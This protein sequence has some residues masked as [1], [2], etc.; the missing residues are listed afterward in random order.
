MCKKQYG[1]QFFLHFRKILKAPYILL[2]MTLWADNRCIDLEIPGRINCEEF[3]K[4]ELMLLQHT[5]FLIYALNFAVFHNACFHYFI[6]AKSKSNYVM[7]IVGN[8]LQWILFIGRFYRMFT[9]L[10]LYLVFNAVIRCTFR[11]LFSLIGS[12]YRQYNIMS[13][14]RARW[15]PSLPNLTWVRVQ[16]LSLDYVEITIIWKNM[17]RLSHDRVASRGVSYGVEWHAREMQIVKLHCDD[18]I[19]VF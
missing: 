10:P 17:Q 14:W 16:L 2:E 3:V 7:S 9:F 13:I 18:W 1:V 4:L 5:E 12:P 6:A 8:N 15:L 19:I 11:V